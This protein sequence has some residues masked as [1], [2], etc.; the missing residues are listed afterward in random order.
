MPS[1]TIQTF[2]DLDAYG[3][4]VRAEFVVTADRKTDAATRLTTINLQRIWMQRSSETPAGIIHVG[5][6]PGRLMVTFPSQPAPELTFNGVGLPFGKIMRFSEAQEHYVLA[7]G[8]FSWA[9][10]GLP[11][12]DMIAAGEA[13]VGQDLSPPRGGL[14]AEPE[15]GAIAKLVRLH[16]AVGR[17]AEDAPEVIANPATAHGLEQ[18]LIETMV[19]C[20]S[21]TDGD[22]NK[23][24]QRRHDLIMHRF[25]RRME[26]AV[27]TPLYV[28]EVCGAIGV[29]HRTLLL[30]CQEYLG[31]G[32]KRYLL[33]RRLNLAR[34]DLQ[35]ARIGTSVTEIATKYGF[36]GF[37]RFAGL[38]KSVFGESP[39]DTLRRADLA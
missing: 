31:M 5:L 2:S 21:G 15:P 19:N 29:P 24:A 4:A 11:I 3:A 34:R 17:L 6:P 25:Y 26:E 23:A 12:E 1:S 7:A 28:P 38:Y 33:L 9:C 20:L 13:L 35:A 10:I 16:A 36:W 18:S 22:D 30:C 39:S 14:I 32:P 8:S 27:D 37:G